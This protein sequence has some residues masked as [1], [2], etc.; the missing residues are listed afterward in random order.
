MQRWIFGLAVVAAIGLY[1]PAKASIVFE[2][3]GKEFSG[4]AI[5]ISNDAVTVTLENDLILSDV[6][7]LTIAPSNMPQDGTKL[8]FL[9]LNVDTPSLLGNLI[10]TN[11]SGPVAESIAQ[12][13]KKKDSAF[14]PDQY[15]ADGDGKYDLLFT[16]PPG[17]FTGISKSSVYLIE[18][19]SGSGLSLSE[20]TFKTMSSSGG[21]KGPFEAAVHLNNV[22]ADGDSGWYAPTDG[23]DYIPEP[24][25]IIV[26]GLLVAGCVGGTIR[27]RKQR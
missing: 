25:S 13:W 26:W 6:V 9:H 22:D 20:T 14:L 8:Q 19:T 3:G 23:G 16:W 11:Q 12:G 2:L 7:W 4:T 17:T 15:Q 5:N 24:A 21:G 18:L 10:F 27:R 1:A